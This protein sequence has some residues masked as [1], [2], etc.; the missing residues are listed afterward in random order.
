MNAVR[1]SSQIRSTQLGP[2]A[3]LIRRLLSTRSCLPRHIQR[4]TKIQPLY[5]TITGTSNI[6]SPRHSFASTSA[7]GNASAAT[8]TNGKP[9]RVPIEV[10]GKTLEFSSILLRDSCSCPRCVHEH[11]NQRLFSTADIPAD[12][13]ACS[14]EIDASSESI[15]IKWDKDVHGH[16]KDHV[17]NLSVAALRELS[18]SGSL[19]G[20][21]KDSH[22]PQVLWTREPLN[23]QDF[24][25]Q[26]Y[27][28]DDK[29][30]YKLIQQLRTDGLAFVTNVPGVEK[31][32]AE[33]VTRIGPVKDTFYG[34]T[35][36]VRTLPEAINAAY[37][38]HDLGFHT[39]LLYFYDP[40]HVQ[41]LHCIQSASTGGAS[42]FADAYKAAVDL[43][44]TDPEAFETLAT[45]PVNYHYNHPDSNVYRITKPVIDLR[46]LRLGDRSYASVQ[47][48]V[49]DWNELN[50]QNGGS[51]WSDAVLVNH[52]QKINWGPPFLAP[53]SNHQDP[54]LKYGPRQPPLME[55]NDKVDKWHEAAFKFNA[56]LQRSEYLFERNMNSG[57][58]FLFEN[59]RTLHS[60]RAFEAADVGKPRWLRGTYVDKDS[61]FSQLRVLKNRFGTPHYHS[62]HPLTTCIYSS[63]IHKHQH[64]D[65]LDVAMRQRSSAREKE[66]RNQRTAVQNARPE[67]SDVMRDNPVV[68]TATSSDVHVPDIKKKFVGPTNTSLLRQQLA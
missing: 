60:R 42:V 18:I 16:S 13:Q 33:I 67:G 8:S 38:S 59:T 40:P 51:G 28:K 48:Y 14:V 6:I 27:M 53:F 5:R 4:I 22:E 35:W 66:Y 30:V 68:T 63:W 25:Y 62:D 49:K 55:L 65:R 17:T 12:I 26:E 20:F 15:N 19:P 43:F 32:V 7:R 54:M 31:S 29:A 36:D 39:D 46:P 41:L 3:A 10:D 23:L 58:W 1:I 56:L 9:S 45:V 37:T 47:Y 61:Y 64:Q 52:M 44:H 34:H 11:S 21:G 2:R 24:D 57:D 50:I